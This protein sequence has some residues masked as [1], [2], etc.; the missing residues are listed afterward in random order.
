VSKKPK[1]KPE[2]HAQ[3][4]RAKQ[5]KLP[6]SLRPIPAR[7]LKSMGDTLRADLADAKVLDLFAGT[8]RFGIMALEEGAQSSEFVEA[9][10]NVTIALTRE[11][12]RYAEKVKIWRQKVD[13][14]LET[15]DRTFDVIFADPPFEKLK[16]EDVEL[17]AQRVLPRLEPEGIFLV[18]HPSRMLTS[19]R[20]NGY[21]YWKQSSVGDAGL[22][23]FV[24]DK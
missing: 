23:Y 5:G 18:K 9:D 13:V 2:D 4:S 22:T 8:G 7:L 11:T 1:A 20:F 3:S 14:F 16:E 21:R 19:P 24:A 6:D 12:L 10:Q 17:L 15:C